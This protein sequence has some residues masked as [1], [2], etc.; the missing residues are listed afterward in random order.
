MGQRG[1]THA[2]MGGPTWYAR[3]A[4]QVRT[5]PTPRASRH[6]AATGLIGAIVALWTAPVTTERKGTR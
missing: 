6:D 5:L 4:A 1:R 3:F 2:D